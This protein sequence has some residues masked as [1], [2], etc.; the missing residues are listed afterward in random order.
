MGGGVRA[1]ALCDPYAV[2][3]LVDGAVALLE[4][5]EEREG[6]DMMDEGEGGGEEEKDAKLQLIWPEIKVIGIVRYT[7]DLV[8]VSSL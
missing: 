1:C 6:E 8:Y 5:V 2:I 3:L 4:L 7:L